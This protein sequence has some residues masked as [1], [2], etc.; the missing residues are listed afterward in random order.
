[1][2]NTPNFVSL[3]CERLIGERL[4]NLLVD[5][6]DVTKQN[7][8]H[9]NHFLGKIARWEDFSQEIWNCY[10]SLNEHFRELR[11]HDIAVTELGEDGQPAPMVG[12]RCES[13]ASVH[14]HWN[15]YCLRQVATVAQTLDSRSRTVLDLAVEFSSSR[16]AEN[17]TSKCLKPKSSPIPHKSGLH[18]H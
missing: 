7:A 3:D 18:C 1:M 2:V 6:N 4:P 10:T 17:N 11:G 12:I 14:G 13:E 16:T 5:E 8:L 15:E 9:D